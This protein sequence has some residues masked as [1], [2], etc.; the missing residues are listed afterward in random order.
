MKVL[1]SLYC[2]FVATFGINAQFVETL[3]MGTPAMPHDEWVTQVVVSPNGKEIVS[4]SIDGR[5][6]FWDAAT[7]K[8]TRDLML[9]AMVLSLSLAKD[10]SLLAAADSSGTVSI[11]EVATAKIK[12]KFTADKHIANA[13]A[14]SDDGKVVAAG[15]SDGIVRIASATDGKIVSEINPARGDIMALT[16]AK[17]HLVIGLRD[18]K[19]GKRSADVWDWQNRKS[20]RTFDEGPSGMRAISLS[21]DGQLL[22]IADYQQPTLLTMTPT[23]GSGAEVSLRV[24]ADDDDGTMVAIWDMTSGKRDALINAETGARALAFSPNGQFLATA[25]PNGIVIHEIGSRSFAEIGRIDSRT[26]VDSVVFSADS[27]Q[28]IFARERQPL[29]KFGDGGTDKLVDPFFTSMVMQVR[30]GL[31]TGVLSKF[32]SIKEPAR[33]GANSVTGGSTVEIWQIRPRTSAA[34]TKT[35][36]AVKNVFSDKTEDAR[37]ILQRVI[38]EH[39]NYGEAQR[40]WAV[41]FERKD[42]EK[43]QNLLQA[44][45]KS[46]S[47]CVACWRSLG[48]LQYQTKQHLEAIKSYD[49]ALQ[50]RPD[51]GLVE[52]HQAHAYGA[53]GLE[54]LSSENT[55]QTMD[56]AKKA[57]TSALTLRPGVEQFYTNLGAAYYFRGD[58]DSNINLLLIAKRLRPDHARIYYNLGHAYRYKGDKV[59]AI[60]AYKQYVAMGEKGEE[61]RVERAKQFIAELS[62]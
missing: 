62:K 7:G 44:A 50:L 2:I 48:D 23:G 13:V 55:E 15:G 36:E 58:F 26:S 51:Y 3:S 54:L 52:G 21:P 39:P 31:N 16:F 6:V 24:L 20:L 8:Q 56:L 19:D 53:L 59:R 38:K 61:A 17:V 60:E 29:V 1:F 49:R 42:I 22:A 27:K 41:L 30:Q 32:A 9:S 46:D 34:D 43:M 11:I 47:N 57:L 12:A 25:G 10:G 33:K 37:Q 4:G 28:L 40:L 14:L 45:V 5:I 18:G 35:W